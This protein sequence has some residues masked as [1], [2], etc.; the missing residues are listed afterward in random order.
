MPNDNPPALYPT[1]E[2]AKPEHPQPPVSDIAVKL[3][4]DVQ[5]SV[6]RI[7]TTD[8]KAIGSGF[9][10]DSDGKMATALHVVRNS[11]ELFA[12]ING[13]RHRMKLTDFDDE[14]DVAI[15]TPVTRFSTKPMELGASK[16]TKIDDDLYAFG[17]PLGLP[18]LYVSPGRSEGT[19]SQKDL[20]KQNGAAQDEEI[21]K[22]LKT[23]STQVDRTAIEVYLNR[24]LITAYMQCQPGN[25]GGPVT[26]SKGRVVGM[27]EQVI[28]TE[29]STQLSP[30]EDVKTLL[31]KPKYNVSHERAFDSRVA[32]WAEARP[33]EALLLGAGYAGLGGLSARISYRN[34]LAARSLGVGALLGGS[35]MLYNDLQ[36]YDR[37]AD[38]SSMDAWRGRAEITSDAILMAGG[39][40]LTFGSARFR[41][42]GLCATG[43]GILGRTGSEFIPTAYKTS[44]VGRVDGSNRP[45]LPEINF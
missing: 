11:P 26:D 41:V 27:T 25:S 10:I 40:A 1:L 22:A 16:D 6:A 38:L 4:E 23:I 18:Q 35:G 29:Q 7:S 20:I 43:A 9:A 3:Y 30:I 15:L 17:H 34:P 21:A 36:D 2:M 33:E 32:K 8:N 28:P 24:S 42:L 12:E 31:E 44:V 5:P 45:P 13:K 37:K 39:A 14:K 19:V